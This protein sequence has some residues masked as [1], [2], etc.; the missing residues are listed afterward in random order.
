MESFEENELYKYYDESF[1]K[2]LFGKSGSWF[3]DFSI[4]ENKWL[5]PEIKYHHYSSSLLMK[6]V[7]I[8]SEDRSMDITRLLLD[9]EMHYIT[10]PLLLRYRLAQRSNSTLYF[11]AGPGINIFISGN[12]DWEYHK[13]IE[14]GSELVTERKSTELEDQKNVSTSMIL[15]LGFS[16]ESFFMEVRYEGCL[17][18]MRKLE[19][20][21]EIGKEYSEIEQFLHS[22]YDYRNYHISIN[23][24]YKL[25]RKW[26]EKV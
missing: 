12:A 17:T 23:L 3:F 21:Y 19:S 6:N 15:S 10:F 26:G 9:V 5:Q 7:V 25:G 11:L 8:E 2:D 20:S 13:Y 16:Y 22:A 4:S 24:G 18:D 1:L 14:N